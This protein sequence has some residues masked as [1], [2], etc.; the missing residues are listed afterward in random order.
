MCVCSVCIKLPVSCFH[1]DYYVLLCI[2]VAVNVD[3]LSE[4]LRTLYNLIFKMF[5]V[6][7]VSFMLILHRGAR[8]I[9]VLRA[10]E[11]VFRIVIGLFFPLNV[12]NIVFECC[13]HFF[14]G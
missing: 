7:V 12:V 5:G 10:C 1:L 9:Q 4:H 14:Q 6:Y 3:I 2:V 11:F 13:Q 8:S